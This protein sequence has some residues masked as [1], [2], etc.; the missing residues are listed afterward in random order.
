MTEPLPS[1]MPADLIDPQVTR[2]LEEVCD[3][4]AAAIIESDQPDVLYH[5]V[6]AGLI[7]RG[8][9]LARQADVDQEHEGEDVIRERMHRLVDAI[10][11][12]LPVVSRTAH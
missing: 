2:I 3:A 8:V 9:L 5:Q 1:P 6:A 12:H 11:E 10:F 4:L 7:T